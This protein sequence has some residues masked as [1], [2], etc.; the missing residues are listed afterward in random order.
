MGQKAG[1]RFKGYIKEHYR[2]VFEVLALSGNWDRGSY[3][4]P[5][6]KLKKLF[7]SERYLAFSKNLRS[8]FIPHGSVVALSSQWLDENGNP[9]E[10]F[11]LDYDS[12]TGY[13]KFQ[14]ELKNYS[15]TIEKFVEMIPDLCSKVEHL[16]Y[17][18]ED[19][20]ES[21]LY[22]MG[23]NKTYVL[24]NEVLKEGLL[25]SDSSQE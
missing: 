3:I 5:T 2:D 23:T 22:A 19:W 15:G 14:C 9:T 18:D 25:C 13:W 8:A 4:N 17:L 24:K 1:L 10:G 20:E 16:E 21:R 6:S 12:K 11:E 7:L